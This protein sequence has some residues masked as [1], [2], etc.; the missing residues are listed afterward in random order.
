MAGRDQF[1]AVPTAW[2]MLA[3]PV[4]RRYGPGRRFRAAA[5]RWLSQRPACW[6]RSPRTGTWTPVMSSEAGDTVSAAVPV[7]GRW[8]SPL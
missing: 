1:V 6:P 5:D 7:C 3:E 2:L 4:W 8:R